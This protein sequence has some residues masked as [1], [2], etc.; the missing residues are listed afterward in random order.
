[1]PA[2]T[3]GNMQDRKYSASIILPV[4]AYIVGQQMRDPT[5]MKWFE[6][7]RQI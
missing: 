3:L 5:Q 1:M 4:L 7:N 2:I 6:T